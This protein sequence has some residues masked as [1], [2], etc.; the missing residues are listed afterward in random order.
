[1]EGSV[2]L[3]DGGLSS[4]EEQQLWG[5]SNCEDGAVWGWSSCEEEHLWG[6]SSCGDG[7]AVRRSSCGDG[8]A[9]RIEQLWMWNSCE[10]STLQSSPIMMCSEAQLT[11]RYLQHYKTSVAKV[12]T[13]THRNIPGMCVGTDIK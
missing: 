10:E 5:W 9:V 12:T 11:L 3:D 1:M 4:C 7:V 8:A 2:A 6:A 13:L